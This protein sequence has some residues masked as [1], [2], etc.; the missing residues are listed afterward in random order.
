MAK[1]RRNHNRQSGGNLM[2][3]IVFAGLL[4]VIAWAGSAVFQSW[5]TEDDKMSPMDRMDNMTFY[6]PVSTTGQIV[7]HDYYALSYSEEHEQA[8][9]VAYLL[10]RERLQKPWVDRPDRFEEDP[11]VRTKSASW[12]DY[13]GSGYD[14]GHLVSAA[15][16]AFDSL[17]MQQT[18][19]MSNISPQDH[20]FNQGIWKEL[21][22][23]TREWAK[24]FKQLYV[25]TG[26]VLKEPIKGKIGDSGVSVP[27]S[28][29]RVLLDLSEPELKGI[30][31]I[32]PN[33]I[34]VTPLQEYAVSIDEVED[35][36]GIDFF[37]QLMT[38]ELEKQL[39]SQKDMSCWPL[40][41]K[42]Y[43]LRIHKWNLE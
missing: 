32:L 39:E 12:Y 37:P 7:L 2:R 22:E 28:Y 41:E 30:G 42:K 1:L 33:E 31:F 25:V 17:A 16:M 43:Q 38:E 18:F 26:P 34:S 23:L 5:K 36:T 6:L 20:F 29:Y 35:R 3:A 14:R 13:R 10:T 19:F 4:A 8:E 40:S 9:W 21:E 27:A 11:E 15:D 24:H